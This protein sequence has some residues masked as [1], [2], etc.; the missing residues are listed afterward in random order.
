MG[1][2]AVYLKFITPPFCYLLKGKP[3]IFRLKAKQTLGSVRTVKSSQS[4]NRAASRLKVRFKR[5]PNLFAL[6][7]FPHFKHCNECSII[8]LM[9]LES[10]LNSL[11]GATKESK[12]ELLINPGQEASFK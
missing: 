10:N 12:N 11:R 1:F 9:K 7:I 2:L 3:R 6:F 8:S 5:L 4:K